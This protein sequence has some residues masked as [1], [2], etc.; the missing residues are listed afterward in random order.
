MILILFNIVPNIAFL[1]SALLPI[2][3]IS[4][5]PVFG[6]KRTATFALI[7]LLAAAIG[8]AVGAV[9]DTFLVNKPLYDFYAIKHYPDYNP[10]LSQDTAILFIALILIAFSFSIL[11]KHL[12]KMV[13]LKA[14][15]AGCIIAL[16][17]I[18]FWY[19]MIDS[20]SLA[21]LSRF[22]IGFILALIFLPLLFLT[23]H[24]KRKKF[25]EKESKKTA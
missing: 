12:F 3:T 10:N 17:N 15:G 6:N 9:I 24:C 20:A 22:Y 18:P 2:I 5:N 11:A 19:Q 8:T 25:L 4:R 16:L 1:A 13:N 21:I 7:F 14:I 23:Y